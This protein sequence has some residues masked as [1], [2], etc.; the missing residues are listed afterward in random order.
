MSVLK[1]EEL[2]VCDLAARI[3]DDGY[4]IVNNLPKELKYCISHLLEEGTTFFSSESE[5]K[6]SHKSIEDGIDVGYSHT[7]NVKEAFQ[8]RLSKDPLIHWTATDF[9]SALET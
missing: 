5:F 2:S 9:K 6:E 1:Y 8:V 3:K 7:R 4:F